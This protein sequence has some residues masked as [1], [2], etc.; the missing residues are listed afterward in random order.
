MDTS[1]MVQVGKVRD[2][3]GLRGELF[4]I[5]SLE[6]TPPWVAQINEFVLVYQSP[7]EGG[8]HEERFKK[9]KVKKTREHKKGFIVKT[10]ELS[11]RN[12]SDSFIGAAFYIDKTYVTAQEGEGL[13]LREVKGCDVYLGATCIGSITGFSSN[14]AQDLLVIKMAQK[15]IEVPFVQQFVERLDLPGK[16]VFMSFPE[17]LLNLDSNETPDDQEN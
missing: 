3:H 12:E 17:D 6:Q 11:T 2:S 16:K 4:I 14:G 1:G 15:T 5:T 13:Y 8:K 10:E 7:N 9:F